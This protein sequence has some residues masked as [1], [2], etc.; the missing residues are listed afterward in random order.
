M[1]NPLNDQSM[2]NVVQNCTAA[3]VTNVLECFADLISASSNGT[4]TLNS[5]LSGDQGC[6]FPLYTVSQILS[7]DPTVSPMNALWQS[8]NAALYS[9]VVS[10][11]QWGYFVNTSQSSDVD[12]TQVFKNILQNKH[13]TKN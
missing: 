13:K 3:G 4:I 2:T 7:L 1:H 5:T 9:S 8:M 12:A 6:L 11:S 10:A